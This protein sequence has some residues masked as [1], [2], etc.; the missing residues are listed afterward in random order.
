MMW[1]LPLEV[2][3]DLVKTSKSPLIIDLKPPIS[4]SIE[5]N[6][7]F[8]P[9]GIMTFLLSTKS[10]TSL[11]WKEIVGQKISI[12]LSRWWSFKYDSRVAKEPYRSRKKNMLIYAIIN[13][14]YLY[15][16]MTSYI[17][18]KII[19][20]INKT[21]REFFYGGHNTYNNLINWD[22][23][24]MSKDEG[25]LSIKDLHIVKSMII[26]RDYYLFSTWRVKE[27]FIIL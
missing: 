20:K 14:I 1:L 25:G 2:V 5:S 27:A 6:L 4:I 12:N 16:L 24:T 13:H 18:D 22:S 15:Y 17:S 23:V 11:I 21:S 7:L 9:L 26:P 8:I 3:K 10:I 19:H